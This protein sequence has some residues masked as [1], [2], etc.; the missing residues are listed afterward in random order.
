MDL[1]EQYLADNFEEAAYYDSKREVQV[2]PLY[3]TRTQGRLLG[4]S[5]RVGGVKISTAPA[6]IERRVGLACKIAKWKTGEYDFS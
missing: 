4:K 3:Y 6:P 1:I 5:S 2:V